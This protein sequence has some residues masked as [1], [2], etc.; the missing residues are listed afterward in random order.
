MYVAGKIIY[1][2]YKAEILPYEDDSLL[3]HLDELQQLVHSKILRPYFFSQQGI[4]IP[5]AGEPLLC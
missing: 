4:T 3:R 2:P 5:N 1:I